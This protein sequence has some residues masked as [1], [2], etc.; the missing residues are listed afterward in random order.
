[1]RAYQTE[2]IVPESQTLT[3]QL[4]PGSPTGRTAQI[5]VLFADDPVEPAA[6]SD[7]PRAGFAGLADFAQWLQAQPAGTRSREDIERQIDDERRAWD[8]N[9]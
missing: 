3:V 1:M 7:L 9:P 8:E 2:Q 6:G 4:P 5:I